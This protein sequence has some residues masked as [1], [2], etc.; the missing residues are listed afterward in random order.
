MNI[1]A[2]SFITCS[3]SAPKAP[4]PA[5]PPPSEQDADVVA[6]RDNERRRRRA[7]ASNTILTSY[8]GAAVQTGAPKTLLGQ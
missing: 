8:K 7:V 4:P 1:K 5:P 6:S 3:G 2:S